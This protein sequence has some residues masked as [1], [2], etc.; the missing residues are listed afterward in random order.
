[1]EN[2][3]TTAITPELGNVLPARIL[4]TA[5]RTMTTALNT[6]AETD[7]VVAMT[8]KDGYQKKIEIIVS[9]ADLSTKE[10]IKAIDDAEDK[11]AQGIAENAQMCKGLMWTKAAIFLACIG[12]VAI[13]GTSP[14]GRRIVKAIIQMAA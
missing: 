11:Y 12:G 10:K 7:R 9:A 2:K 8:P 3:N 6:N 5:E 13:L 4:E 14:K 1:M